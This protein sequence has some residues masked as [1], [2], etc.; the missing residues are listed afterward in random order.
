[1]GSLTPTA[2]TNLMPTVPM[3]ISHLRENDS[4]ISR[5]LTRMKASDIRS[6]RIRLDS[7]ATI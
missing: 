6:R 4:S 1:M 5:E 2:E 7:P 3:K